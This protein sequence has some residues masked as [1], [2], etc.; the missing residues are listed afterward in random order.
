M[1]IKHREKNIMKPIIFGTDL[2]T[3]RQHVTL[4]TTRLKKCTRVK[5]LLSLILKVTVEV[6][7]PTFSIGEKPDGEAILPRPG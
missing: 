1:H 3:D 7:Y 5:L 2:T 4:I 6:V